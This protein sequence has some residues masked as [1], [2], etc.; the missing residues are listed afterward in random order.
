MTTGEPLNR[1]GLFQTHVDS[2]AKMVPFAGWEMPLQY[3]GIFAEAKSVRS[4][5]GIFDVSH[6]GRLFIS[7][8]QAEGLLDKLLTANVPALNDGR[9]RY[10]MIC[11]EQGGIIDDVVIARLGEA[12]YLLV[13]N[14]ANRERV[15]EWTNTL[16]NDFP[17]VSMDDHTIDTCLIA[18]Q[19]P[20]AEAILLSLLGQ[21]NE[22]LVRAFEDTGAAAEGVGDILLSLMGQATMEALTRP[23]GITGAAVE[24]KGAIVSRTGY[25][26]EDG[27]ELVVGAE[28][29]PRVWGRLV[30][31][32][33]SPCGLGARDVLRLEAGLRLH[34]TDMDAQTTPLEAGLGRYVH[35]DGD[36]A[37][38][39]ALVR[40]QESGLTRQLVGLS[41]RG[42]SVAR[43]GYRLLHQGSPVG[44]ISSGTFSPT[45]NASIAMG[46]VPPELAEAG[47]LL[48]VDIR[49]DMTEAEVVALPFYSRRRAS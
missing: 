47:Q 8:R 43:H 27:F 18:L 44:V 31:L 26:G 6:M 14:A 34:G 40:Q 28:Q 32:G 2:G 3:R 33:A 25:T 23:F 20:K 9:A 19:G 46:F 11:N 35:M 1:T 37:G 10:C 29:G 36:F 24:G 13:C 41:V 48:D 15:V 12:R 38:H 30:E 17:N 39:D 45:L 4:D 21:A 49:G 5:A 16:M 7:G 22:E 42:R